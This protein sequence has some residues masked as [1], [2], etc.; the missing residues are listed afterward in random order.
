MNKKRYNQSKLNFLKEKKKKIWLSPTG[1]ESSKRCPRCFW[2][3]YNKKLRQPEGIVSRLANRFDGVIKKYFDLYRP[4]GELP[5][6]IDGQ[7]SGRLQHP[8]QETYFF[9]YDDNYGLMGKLDECLITKQGTYT[10]IDHKTASSDPKT[11]P[12]ISAYQTQL[13]IYAFLLEINKRPPSG[14]GHLIYFF[15]AEGKCLHNGFP[16]QV[17]IKTLK[18]D[19]KR[20]KNEFLKSMDILK[21]PMPIPSKECQF[22]NWHK[23]F[24]KHINSKPTKN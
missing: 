7:V 9:H 16:M 10:P 4:L 11:K 23:E 17:T 12:L 2:I 13:D 19:T 24:N 1:I 3:Q 15:P 20:A 6:L 21:A 14:I 18:T 22:C 8:F 5:P